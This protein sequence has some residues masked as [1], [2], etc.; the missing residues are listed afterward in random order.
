MMVV[1]MNLSASVYWITL[2][3]LGSLL[4]TIEPQEFEPQDFTSR[5]LYT[6][7]VGGTSAT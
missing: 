7:L 4:G 1:L 6:L 3:V 5:I 2:N